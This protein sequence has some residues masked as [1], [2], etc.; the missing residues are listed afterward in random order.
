MLGKLVGHQK[1]THFLAS[2]HRRNTVGLQDLFKEVE[3]SRGGFSAKI[4]LPNWSV[5]L[6]V[7]KHLM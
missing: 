3:A 4:S 5:N 7:C 1:F 6:L 2:G